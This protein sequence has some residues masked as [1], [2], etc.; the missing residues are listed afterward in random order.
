MIFRSRSATPAADPLLFMTGGPG[1]SNVARRASGKQNP[2]LDDRDYVL[3]EPR[4]T[5]FAQPALACPATNALKG[6]IAAGRLP[7][8]PRA[9]R[10]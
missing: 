3:L 5:R 2:F 6:E 10:S 4:G 8:T 7:G 9:M 1:N